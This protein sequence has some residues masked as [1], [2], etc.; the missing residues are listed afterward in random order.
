M[1]VKEVLSRKRLIK[2]VILLELQHL[3]VRARAAT[4]TNAVSC[5]QLKGPVRKVLKEARLTAPF[6]FR[7]LLRILVSIEMESYV[8]ARASLLFVCSSI[9]KSH[10]RNIK[11]L[12]TRS[13]Y[14]LLLF[15]TY[16]FTD[17]TIMFYQYNINLTEF[18]K[19]DPFHSQLSHAL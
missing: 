14:A 11:L 3:L 19:P 5:F 15:I 4:G 18:N 13:E 12:L 6:V 8:E 16:V 10:C 1:P 2:A 9:Y 17:S 7:S